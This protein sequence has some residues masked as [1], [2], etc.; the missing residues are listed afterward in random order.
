MSPEALAWATVGLAAVPAVLTVWNL[1][2]YRRSRPGTLA[3]SRPAVSILIPA[4]DEEE[5]IAEA[6]EAALG[7]RDVD[8]E[9]LVLDDGSRD[10]TAEIVRRRAARDPRLRLLAGE[11]PPPGWG[12]KPHACQQLGRAARGSVLLFVDADVVLEPDAASRLA[13]T[14]ERG[15]ADLLSGVPRQLTRGPVERLVVPLIHSVLLGYLPMALMRLSGHPAFAAG[16]GQLVAV[17]RTSWESMGGHAGVAASRHDGLALARQ[18]RRHG[19]RTDLADATDLARCRMYRSARAVWTGF[20]KNATEGMASPTAILPWTLL[21]LGGQVL[22]YALLATAPG[23][24]AA[25]LASGTRLVLALRFRLPASG[26][27]LHPLGV[28]IL[29]AIQWYAL[30]L[31]LAGR[32]PAWKGRTS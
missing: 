6:I 16:C 3:S 22:P 23:I 7:S 9:V 15:G 2:L 5:V 4:R 27:L 24:A 28:L 25:I 32:R 1:A 18:M 19:F 10:R 17:R 30:A 21:L 8:L 31:S 14:L 20:A 12:G 11:G 29:L 13:D 26:V